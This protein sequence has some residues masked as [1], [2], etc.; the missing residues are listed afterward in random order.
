MINRNIEKV[1]SDFY[2]VTTTEYRDWRDGYKLFHGKITDNIFILYGNGGK[3]DAPD[4]YGAFIKNDNETIINIDIHASIFHMIINIGYI[5]FMA[6]S[7]SKSFFSIWLLHNNIF[8]MIFL[9]FMIFIIPIIDYGHYFYNLKSMLNG[10][11]LFKDGRYDKYI[12][13]RPNGT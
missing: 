2:K 3:L 11:Y 1:K 5:I 4:F 6:N 7:V 12:E 13:E 8:M 9:I 10:L